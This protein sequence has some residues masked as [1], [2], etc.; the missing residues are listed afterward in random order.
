MCTIYLLVRLLITNCSVLNEYFLLGSGGLLSF[1]APWET[2]A[3]YN[4]IEAVSQLRGE[5][6]GRQVPNARRALVYGASLN[7]FF[8]FPAGLNEFLQLAVVYFRFLL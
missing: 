3:M 4:I 8:Y 5:A 6:V 7:E 1:G 2:P